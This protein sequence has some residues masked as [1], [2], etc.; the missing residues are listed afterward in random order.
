M[1]GLTYRYYFSPQKEKTHSKEKKV[2][3]LGDSI[4]FGSGVIGTR[5]RSAWPYLLNEKLPDYVE[6]LNY[7]ISGATMLRSGD[8]PYRE[9]FLKAVEK[10]DP[11][12]LLV[13]LGTNDSKSQNWDADSFERDYEAFL[14]RFMKEVREVILMLPPKAFPPEGQTEILFQIRDRVIAGEVIPIIRKL[15]EQNGLPV[16]DL[17]KLTEDHS[18]YFHHGVHPNNLGNK[19]LAEHILP[20]L[21]SPIYEQNAVC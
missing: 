8:K 14:K 4:T 13:M 21:Y 10:I 1:S 17:Y 16:I 2:I 19:I 7:G 18:E 6:V 12:T 20:Y 11:D 5:R 9:S 15:A 3:C